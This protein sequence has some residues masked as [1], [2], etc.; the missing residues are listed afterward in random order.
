MCIPSVP[1]IISACTIRRDLRSTL[2]CRGFVD[3]TGMRRGKKGT[4]ELLGSGKKTRICQTNSGSISSGSI[5]RKKVYLKKT[6][7]SKL[8]KDTLPPRQAIGTWLRFLTDDIL[9]PS[10]FVL[11]IIL[12]FLSCFV[13]AY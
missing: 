13:T 1:H 2:L 11:S 7:Q 12:I 4:V 6:A 10:Q 3:P 8:V 5:A 9:V